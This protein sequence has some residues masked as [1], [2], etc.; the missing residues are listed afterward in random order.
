M[1]NK[2]KNFKRAF[3]RKRKYV[4]LSKRKLHVIRH[5]K[6]PEKNLNK[7]R[8]NEELNKRLKR[9]KELKKSRNDRQRLL[10][11]VYNDYRLRRLKGLLYDKK[12]DLLK[13]LS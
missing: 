10:K 6:L 12:K 5:V 2:T 13:T 3:L 4:R 1:R 7:K 8:L 9:Y 11:D